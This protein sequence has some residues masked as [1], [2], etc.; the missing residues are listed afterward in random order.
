[1][2]LPLEEVEI[3]EP[4]LAVSI[5][6]LLN[7]DSVKG[8]LELS[9]VPGEFSVWA[10]ILHE[11]PVPGGLTRSEFRKVRSEFL[12]SEGWGGPGSVTDKLSE[13]D[14]RLES[15]NQY[16][17]VVMWFEHDL[18][19]QLI[20]IHHLNFFA[21][22]YP[23]STRLSLICIGDFPGVDRFVGLGQL[24][25]DQLASL[26]PFRSEVTRQQI[27]LGCEAWAAFTSPD[28]AG[29]VRMISSNTS[30]LPFLGDALIRFLE[31]YPSVENGLG[32]TEQRALELLDKGA[33]YFH[34]LFPRAMNSEERPFMGDGPYWMRLKAMAE[35]AHPLVEM[36]HRK[37]SPGKPGGRI[38]I[39]DVGRQVMR[40]QADN[41]E[42]NG[43]GRWL[44]GV[45][46]S[47]SNAQWRWDGRISQVV[48]C[49]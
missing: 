39:T 38:S 13:W 35:A 19:D 7:G 42:L 11:G 16:D 5:L 20:L 26:F 45:H 9:T 40:M 12:S 17:E 23:S 37:S 46:L 34:D 28:P 49:K 8:T 2:A 47:G 43:I 25:A 3:I 18:F 36:E 10:D 41:I 1:M 29:L 31:E 32:R 27:D 6:H 33:L 14:A 24:T 21:E 48:S 30:A 44:G 22:Y 15:F 4:E